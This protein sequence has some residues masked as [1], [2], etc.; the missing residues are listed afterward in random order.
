MI[1]GSGKL[2]LNRTS[3]GRSNRQKHPVPTSRSICTNKRLRARKAM[4]L[5]Q[6]DLA[7]ESGLIAVMSAV[8]N[9]ER[10]TLLSENSARLP[11][12]FDATLGV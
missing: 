11:G 7:L 1:G 5:S 10:E 12:Q 3:R 6:E 4:G 9:V 8:W 2:P